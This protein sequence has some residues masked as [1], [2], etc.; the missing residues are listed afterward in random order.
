VTTGD[1]ALVVWK[2]ANSDGVRDEMN[3]PI[4]EPEVVARLGSWIE[5]AL[6]KIEAM[7]EIAQ[8]QLENLIK[9][10]NQS[11]HYSIGSLLPLT[12]DM[13]KY[14]HVLWLT[15]GVDLS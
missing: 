3:S 15:L 9:N 6:S 1:E 5:T 12:Q 2:H 14:E 8:N 13:Y 7:V 11:V 4:A 10:V